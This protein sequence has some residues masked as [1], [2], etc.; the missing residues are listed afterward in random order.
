MLTVITVKL[1]E[2]NRNSLIGEEFLIMKSGKQ[3]PHKQL[4]YDI[5]GI[6]MEVHTELGHGFAERVYENSLAYLL[7]SENFIVK[8]QTELPVFFRG[9]QVG[10][11]KTDLIVNDKVILELKAIQRISNIERAQTLNYLKA[12]N[13]GLALIINFGRSRLEHERLVF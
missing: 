4:T 8:Q 2:P 13:I 7:A 12:T 3:F 1:R 9:K 10:S 6:A 5:I 11:Y